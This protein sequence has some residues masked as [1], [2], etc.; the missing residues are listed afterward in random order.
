MS[1]V[2]RMRKRSAV[3]DLIAK[4]SDRQRLLNVLATY[5]PLRYI[6]GHGKDGQRKAE[7]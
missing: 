7:H 3:F 4:R 2:S 5:F 1:Y 6:L